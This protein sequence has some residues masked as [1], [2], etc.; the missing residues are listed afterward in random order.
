[1]RFKPGQQVTP[2]M[3]PKWVSVMDRRMK[4]DGPKHGEIVT[5]AEYH[6]FDKKYVAFHEYS[7]GTFFEDDFEPL[8]SDSIL[9][10]QL[11]EVPE[12]FTI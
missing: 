1:M 11:A 4:Y 7:V 12:P 3:K 2:K 10:E 5:V 9:S 6:P 8:V